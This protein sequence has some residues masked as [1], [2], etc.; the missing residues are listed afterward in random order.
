MKKKVIDALKDDKYMFNPA[1]TYKNEKGTEDKLKKKK[2]REKKQLQRRAQLAEYIS[3]D[4]DGPQKNQPNLDQDDYGALGDLDQDILGYFQMK[5]Q[6]IL[7]ITQKIPDQIFD[8]GSLHLGCVSQIGPN[9][10]YLIINF[11]RNKKGFVD[12]HNLR[13]RKS[14]NGGDYKVGEYVVTKVIEE[15]KNNKV[16]LSLHPNV[17]NDQL[18]VNQIVVGMQIS[19]I[20]QTWNEFGT[21]INFGTEQFSGFINE[22]KLKCGRVYLFNIKEINLK[23]KIVICDF[24]QREVQLQNKKQISKYLLTPGNIW[25]CNIAKSITGGQIVKLNKFGV[26]GYIFQDYQVEQEKNFQ[27]RIIGFDE[28]SRQI[29]LSSKQEH[30]DNTIYI[31][32]YEV[33]QQYQG[34][35][36]NQQLYSGAYLFNAI[37]NDDEVST[38]KSKKAK[39]GQQPN[40]GPIC[41]LNK[42]QIPADQEIIDHI[43]R[44]CII[45]EINYFDHIG[46]VSFE[47]NSQPK[48]SDLNVGAIVKGV[49]KQVLLKEDSYSVLLKINDNFNAILPSIQMSDY[50]L[51]NPPKFRVGSKIRVRILQIDE[52]HNNIIVTMK[53]TLLTDI[54]VFKTLDD[55]SVGDTLYGFTIKKLENG[56]LV[57]FFQNIV[58]FLSNFSLDGQNPDDIKDG[59]IIK[60]YVKYINQSENKLLLSLKKIDPKQKQVNE[61][62][63]QN[64]P[65]IKQVKTKLNLGEKVQCIVS[66][67]KNNVVYVNLKDG[68]FGRIHKAFFECY[69]N[70]DRLFKL[71]SE[72]ENLNVGSQITAQILGENKENNKQIFDLTCLSDHIELEKDVQ[73]DSNKIVYGIIKHI[74]S[75]SKSP[76]V[77]Q[78][79]YN[80]NV[81]IDGWDINVEQ[82]DILN[83]LESQIQQGHPVKIKLYEFDKQLKG[84]IITEDDQEK[85]QQQNI[86]DILY[87][88]QIYRILSHHDS[89]IRV[90]L[91][92]RQF[93]SIDITELQELWELNLFEQFPVGRWGVCR[94]I[95]KDKVYWA[96]ARETFLNDKLWNKCLHPVKSNTISYQKMI[97]SLKY[98]VRTQLYK[99]TPL[100]VGQVAIGYVTGSTYNGTFVKLNYETTCLI[101]GFKTDI[102]YRPIVLMITQLNKLQGTVDLNLLK[103]KLEDKQLRI[104]DIV[105]GLVVNIR[106]EKAAIK[107]LGTLQQGE[108]DKKDAE[109]LE[110][111]DGWWANKLFKIGQQIQ[112]LVI[113]QRQNKNNQTVLRLSNLQELIKTEGKRQ[114]ELGDI[115]QDVIELHESFEE[116]V[117]QH[118]IKNNVIVEQQNQ[119]KEIEEEEI[120]QEVNEGEDNEDE[121][122]DVEEEE[123]H[124]DQEIEEENDQEEIREEVQNLESRAEYEKKILINPNSSVIWIEFVAYA[125]ENE[126]IESARNIIERALRVINFSNELERLN[127]W[128]AYLNLEFNFGSEDNL[129][130]VFKRGC[131]NCDGKKLHIKLINIYRKAEKVDLTVELSRSFV[132][133]YKQSCK[134][135]MEFLQSLMEWQKVHDDENPQYSFKDTLNR[136]MQ[137]LK[138]TK[139]VKLLSFYGRLQ[140]QNNQI[141]EGKTTYETILDKN[142]TR[143]DIWS[144]YLDLVIKYCQPDVVRSIFQKAIH[145]NKKPRKIK[146]LFKKQLEY[147]NQYGDSATIQKVKE[148]AEQW[149]SQFMQRDAQQE[150][151]E[152]SD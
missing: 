52:Q 98:D 97:L 4:D 126:G 114:I 152:D 41:M 72:F 11:T 113:G 18:S 86:N 47:V 10:A 22:Q 33:G 115:Q 122:E 49:V 78:I 81:F 92:N 147:E 90:Q 131:Q 117:K 144:Q 146:F 111:E 148:Q 32:P 58:G 31:P 74:K 142:S 137:C 104:G 136:A 112:C 124:K 71:Q 133:K 64:V 110:G 84:I 35:V 38:K 14:V 91:K 69:R 100:A 30:I 107:I 44:S 88:K 149:V 36:I 132:Q 8:I 151:E 23:E 43:Q 138:K 60:V 105:Q 119:N 121:Q 109:G 7:N 87:T 68:K 51:T 48:I 21:T 39:K 6:K 130:S 116:M 28:P 15:N 129:I 26:L 34:V 103:Y 66:A 25:K 102:K 140:F 89:Y 79:Y 118:Q 135:W 101:R 12:Q 56:I 127:L 141:E 83:N 62:Q 40:L 5:S 20:A 96:S 46:F 55:I 139:Q 1:P 95:A 16:Q 145:N 67:I 59:Q 128:T 9:G 53:P 42:T 54:K 106:N 108:L 77:V 27:C 76:L 3:S 82:T 29:Y 125:A 17:I 123:D 37:L 120:G 19:G 134:S 85:K 99:K 80:Y 57:K 73:K 150:D 65:L 63:T 93:A 24:E 61:G 143:T 2:L 94:I 13:D 70:E 50:P 75:D 45:K